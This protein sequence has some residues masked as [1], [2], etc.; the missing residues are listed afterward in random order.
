MIEVWSH[1]APGSLP[2]KVKPDV[3]FCFAKKVPKKAPGKKPHPA[4]GHL[5]HTW[6]RTKDTSLISLFPD[7]SLM[8]LLCYCGELLQFPDKLS[9]GLL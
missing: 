1:Y 2:V 9:F 6:R 4:V 5:L 7:G 8:K 3:L